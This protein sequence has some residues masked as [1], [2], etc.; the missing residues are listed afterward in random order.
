MEEDIQ[1]K[2]LNE[3]IARKRSVSIYLVNGIRLIGYMKSF[4]KFC[5]LLSN[6][7]NYQLLYKHAVST[8]VPEE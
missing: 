2:Y 4:D 1:E 3:L 6:N 5:I 8:I 7:S